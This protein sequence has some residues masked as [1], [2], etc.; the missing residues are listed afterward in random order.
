MTDLL[1]PIGDI[2]ASIDNPLG[3]IGVLTVGLLLIVGG[4]GY[5]IARLAIYS[6]E[7][8]LMHRDVEFTDALESQNAHIA[9]LT[10]AF[11]HNSQKQNEIFTATCEKQAA[12]FK[13]SMALERETHRA[14]VDMQMEQLETATEAIR[15]LT[16]K[17]DRLHERMVS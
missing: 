14:V 3:I 17:V 8:Y 6:A 2:V 9:R 12:F 15:E 16:R 7:I 11:E 4:G 1:K 13:E 5:L 10:S